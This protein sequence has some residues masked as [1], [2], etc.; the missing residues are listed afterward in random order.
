[1]TGLMNL[2]SAFAQVSYFPV[3][4]EGTDS[5]RSNEEKHELDRSHAGVDDGI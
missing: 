5:N 3:R 2:E 4:Y 1:M